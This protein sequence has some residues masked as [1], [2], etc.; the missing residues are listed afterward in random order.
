MKK[1]FERINELLKTIVKFI[2]RFFM[3]R[4]LF[5]TFR[6][7]DKD[8][9]VILA[10][11]ISFNFLL[12]F[13]PFLILLGSLMGVIIDHIGSSHNISNDQIAQITFDSLK[14]I[15]PALNEQ[16]I[17]E[18]FN[19]SQYK[20]SLGAIGLGTL[21]ISS[22]LLFNIIK[23]AFF[24]IFKGV[25]IHMIFARIFGMLFIVGIVMFTFFLQYFLS[26]LIPFLTD[27]SVKIPAIIPTI[28]AI[29]SNSSL[30]TILSSTV[31][32]III[33]Y[34]LF[35]IF[36]RKASIHFKSIVI[37]ALLFSGLWNLAKSAFF[38]Y[39]TKISA[40]SIIYGSIAWLIVI[41]L[42]VYYSAV[43][44]LLSLE[45]IKSLNEAIQQKAI[46][47]LFF[48]NEKKSQ[49]DSNFYC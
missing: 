16:T 38:V 48:L 36:A 24:I 43:I 23:N 40:V 26:L 46:L 37:G 11:S 27:L 35:A 31:F 5:N 12:S 2:E 44:F 19:I 29:K 9:C 13:I 34:L 17:R 41:I 1:L 28:E 49:N 45:F 39:L 14:N 21:F 7:F 8:G 4:V 3:L 10:S 20:T 15:F 33:F 22:S 25:K 18:F 32:T 47:K 42:W 6:G 30:L